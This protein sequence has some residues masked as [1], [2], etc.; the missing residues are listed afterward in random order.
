MPAS[1]M[2]RLAASTC[3]S[4]ELEPGSFPTARPASPALSDPIAR[5]LNLALG[6]AGALRKE[7]SEGRAGGERAS[8]L[9]E[10]LNRYL[11]GARDK[12]QV[13][14]REAA[15][16]VWTQPRNEALKLSEEARAL[17]TQ[18]QALPKDAPL[19]FR[20]L[21]ELGD[22]LTRLHE[23]VAEASRKRHEVAQNSIRNVK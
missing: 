13:Q 8:Q 9:L 6:L 22:K 15:D 11:I 12:S 5:Q 16:E 2:A 19:Q 23:K 10:Q 21:Q 4:T 7:A 17:I 14:D 18:L 1:S 20:L 3:S